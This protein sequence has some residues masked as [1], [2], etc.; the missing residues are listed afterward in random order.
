MTFLNAKIKVPV[1]WKREGATPKTGFFLRH[2]DWGGAIR[3]VRQ[4]EEAVS[5]G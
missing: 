5:D 1:P 3:H 4:A 2:P